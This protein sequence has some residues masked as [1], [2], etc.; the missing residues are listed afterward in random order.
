MNGDPTQEPMT[1]MDRLRDVGLT[2]DMP[3]DELRALI[4]EAVQ[5]VQD[6]LEK[7][8]EDHQA[9]LRDF[10]RGAPRRRRERP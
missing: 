2:P 4:A 5:E 3:R 9:W 1:P 7:L 8:E 10:R 6:R